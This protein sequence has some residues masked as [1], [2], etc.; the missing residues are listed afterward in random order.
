MHEELKG[1]QTWRVL[2]SLPPT[3][4]R[5]NYRTN[6]SL[7]ILAATAM[8]A[9]RVA[10]ERHPDADVSQVIKVYGDEVLRDV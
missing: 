3:E 7:T 6:K 5:P 8:G 2:L 10:L 9:L 1:M 4:K